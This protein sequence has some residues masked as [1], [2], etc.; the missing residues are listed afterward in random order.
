[1][2]LNRTR[3]LPVLRLACLLAVFAAA[4]ALAQMLARPGWAGFGEKSEA[5]WKHPIVYEVDPHGFSAEGLKGIAQRLDYIHSLG[6]DAIL[7][8]RI[9]PDAAHPQELDPA[10]GTLDDLD[11]LSR[12]ASSRNMRILLDL[13]ALPSGTDLNSLAR[14]WLNRGLAGFRIADPRQADELRKI[15][16][17]YIGERIIIGDLDPAATGRQQPQLL[18]DASLAKVN[19]LS[20]AALRPVIEAIQSNPNSL[21]LA[22][23]G[24]GIARSAARLGDGQHN[25]DIAK[26]L[27]AALL[28]NRA[29]SL[30]YYGQ[31]IGLAS[32]APMPWGTPVAP[33]AAGARK[34]AHPAPA[35]DPVSVAAQEAD[36]ASLLHWYRQLSALHHS[37]RTL[38]SAPGIVL[39]HDDQNVLAWV[40]K[41][42]GAS[43]KNPPLVVICN[44]SAQPVHLSLKDDMQKL[45][46]KG[47]F[48]RTVIRSDKG[49]GPMTLDSMTI[50]AFTVYIGELKY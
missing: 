10:I 33:A 18:L 41:P 45:H 5:W 42:E 46:L 47:N 34:P 50:P 23:D 14:L 25:F 12:A 27:A 40:R 22:T 19:Q 43:L 30:I 11:D 2:P 21:L 48:L 9:E 44:L 39:N 4:P 17:S 35:N 29:S 49:M 8:T 3:S 37:N 1:M 7:L 26:I 15:A 38:S 31:E 6:A 24:P 32:D 13:G 36:P 28:T 20:A 16:G